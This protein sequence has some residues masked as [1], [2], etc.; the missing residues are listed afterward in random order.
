MYIYTVN[1]RGKI[2]E[3]R[4]NTKIKYTPQKVLSEYI[5]AAS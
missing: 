3:S 2:N 1:G 4:E 5:P